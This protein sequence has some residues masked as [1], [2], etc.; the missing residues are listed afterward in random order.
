MIM[1]IRRFWQEYNWIGESHQELDRLKNEVIQNVS[2]ELRSPLTVALCYAELLGHGELGALQPDQQEAVNTIAHHLS[3]L[4]GMM[5]NFAAVLDAERG[6]LS[7]E[8]VDLADLVQSLLDRLQTTAEQAELTLTAEIEPDL[9]PIPGDTIQLYR[10]VG[11]LLDN[12]IKFTPAG[13]CVTVRL[14]RGSVA[15]S[16]NGKSGTDEANVVLALGLNSDQ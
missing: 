11:S 15:V 5:D 8:S 10:A 4:K 12:A 13:G 16:S 9:P 3:I 7:Q 2:H 6:K 14:R 1:D